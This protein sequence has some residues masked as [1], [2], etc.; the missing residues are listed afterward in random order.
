M[1]AN[2]SNLQ[3][4]A[5]AGF[6][7]Q[8]PADWNLSLQQGDPRLREGLLAFSDLRNVRLELRWHTVPGSIRK[9]ARLQRHLDKLLRKLQ[10]KLAPVTLNHPLRAHQ[11]NTD[12]RSIVLF[13]GR[14]DRI[15]ELTFPG[16]HAATQAAAVA[17]TFHDHAPDPVWTWCLYGVA[18]E[19]PASYR[20]RRAA[21]FPG[22]TRLEFLPGSFL[23][24]LNAGPIA[25]G[26]FSMAD[27]LL[28]GKSLGDWAREHIP[29]LKN[30]PKAPIESPT[31][32]SLHARIPTRTLLLR[33]RR[34]I[35]FHLAHDAA[36]N[37]L[38]FTQREHAA[39]A[40]AE[41]QSH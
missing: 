25:L 37:V 4:V 27:R 24:R 31:P 36:A 15:Y 30:H 29:L 21:L 33:R 8:L 16:A 2:V 41:S 10:R 23:Q 39:T 6:A 11:I 1:A 32:E 20:L 34:L 40:Q 17:A 26:S 28:R 9:P 13:A 7:L 14:S 18:G 19:V 22:T 38:R 35:D 3:Q 5:W 12:A